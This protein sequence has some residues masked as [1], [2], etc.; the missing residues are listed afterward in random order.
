MTE[1]R[2]D[3]VLL[4]ISTEGGLYSHDSSNCFPI[5]IAVILLDAKTM[6]VM[7]RQTKLIKPWRFH[8]T[9]T[10]YHGIPDRVAFL[11]GEPFRKVMRDLTPFFERANRY[12]TYYRPLHFECLRHECV[13]QGI[14]FPWLESKR[15]M[16]T[17]PA[18]PDGRLVPLTDMC[19]QLDVVYPAVRDAEKNINLLL[20]CLRISKERRLLNNSV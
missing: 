5:Q 2:Q 11:T 9:K 15:V 6:V 17:Q 4:I 1:Q 7:D 19:T 12:V 14:H 18:K 3:P 13:R 20:Q 10:R 8:C 16:D